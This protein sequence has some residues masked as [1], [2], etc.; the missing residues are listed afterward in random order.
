[1]KTK[2]TLL[3]R[4]I[5]L[6][7]LGLFILN[8]LLP[9]DADIL[10]RPNLL[11]LSLPASLP[12]LKGIQINPNNPLELNFVV[13]LAQND[14]IDKD[15]AAKLVKYFLAML[16]IPEDDLWVNLSP[17]ERNR[18]IPET[19]GVT[20]AGKD[21]LLQ[22]YLLKRLVS[23]LTYPETDQ[24]RQFW[25]K[26]YQEI[27]KKTGSAD[28]ALNAFNPSRPPPLSGGE[29]DEASPNMEGWAG[30]I[31]IVPE[32]AVV[33]EVDNVA[34]IKEARLKVMLEEDYKQQAGDSRDKLSE[35]SFQSPVSGLIRET[36]LPAI[37]REVNEGE[38]FATLRQIY[39]SQILAVWFKQKLKNNM[40]HHIYA[41][42][43]KMSG[44]DSVDKKKSAEIYEQ[45]L[46]VLKDG[47]YRYVREEY[48]P[49]SQTINPKVYFS[50]GYSGG[51]A[52]EYLKTTEFENSASLA[53]AA[54]DFHGAEMKV[55]L[56]GI[57]GD[58]AMLSKV[59]KS[60]K[61]LLTALF[62]VG[63]FSS[64]VLAQGTTPSAITADVP[65]I[66]EPVK[67]PAGLS[68]NFYNDFGGPTGGAKVLDYGNAALEYQVG[69][70][71]LKL[72]P[73]WSAD[74]VQRIL[75]LYTE[76][77]A[78]A[79]PFNLHLG[80]RG[81]NLPPSTKLG[82]GYTLPGD[83][84]AIDVSLFRALVAQATQAGGDGGGDDL[85]SEIQYAFL[86]AGTLNLGPFKFEPAV[87]VGDG[88]P[89][90]WQLY[91]TFGFFYDKKLKGY[92]SNI[93][94]RKN[95]SAAASRYGPIPD[96][97]F[98]FG[99]TY[100]LPWLE[101]SPYL[102]ASTL[103]PGMDQNLTLGLTTT[104]KVGNEWEVD[105]LEATPSSGKL[106]F[107]FYNDF[108]KPV[109]GKG[110]L[111]YGNFG[112]TLDTG[113]KFIFS[114]LA[115]TAGLYKDG[116]FDGTIGGY[117]EGDFYLPIPLVLKLG[118]RLALLGTV[119][120]VTFGG[121][122]YLDSSGLLSMGVTLFRA[123][124]PNA[125]GVEEGRFAAMA[126]T[127]FQLWRLKTS[128][129][130]F[131]GSKKDSGKF[132]DYYFM[133]TLLLSEEGHNIYFQRNFDAEVWEFGPLA[134]NDPRL[135]LGFTWPLGNMLGLGGAVEI[136][137]YAAIPS[138]QDVAN[139]VVGLTLGWKP[140]IVFGS[141]D[142]AMTGEDSNPVGGIDLKMSD[143][144]VQ[145]IEKDKA[146][147]VNPSSPV[148]L[149]DFQGF[150]FNITQI[151]PIFSLTTLFN[152]HL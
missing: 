29:M 134:P 113:H 51:R 109:D 146:S 99:Y 57:S 121:V 138:V 126:S 142:H 81:G 98:R 72:M 76:L 50:G 141:S 148:N 48:D 20:D 35:S 114:L 15:E 115:E 11:S 73:E 135:R 18:I 137:P 84:L 4:I 49:T 79:G 5:H 88:L 44:I 132:L 127:D 147:L 128:L 1:M 152:S 63:A 112:A 90:D 125:Q 69:L 116:K 2:R 16:T 78:N 144:N 53:Q 9:A 10:S 97:T 110:G 102:S 31:W 89:L 124:V 40:I 145:V 75:N 118:Q 129:A 87:F 130:A 12:V 131:Y 140:E 67:I 26:V 36:I 106:N 21:L 150:T 120:P 107:L 111:Q 25:D 123:Q 28:I 149:E 108:W 86:A 77:S 56:S 85:P 103:V 32:K 101:I 93:Y 117:L 119:P 13:D 8:T 42:K 143:S 94:A 30:K 71:K 39:H 105:E 24:G 92:T 6:T 139:A 52:K 66:V 43:S 19:L 100:I 68:F 83:H 91:G 7:M 59:I 46:K 74:S 45:Y 58:Q 37:E 47:V 22:D 3:N 60:A 55:E 41:D 133:M 104:F 151:I 17:Y 54:G 64:K 38:N 122:T 80:Q 95:F 61:I 65:P 34:Y 33:Y 136:S 14:T 70:A 96:N 82:L 27:Y 62:F 23:S